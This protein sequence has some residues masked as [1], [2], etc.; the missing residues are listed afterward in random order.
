MRERLPDEDPAAQD[1]AALAR[2]RVR[3]AAV[4]GGVSL[5]PQILGILRDAPA[6]LSTVCRLWRALPRPDGTIARP[7]PHPAARRRLDARPRHAG[8]GGPQLPQPLGRAAPRGQGSM[9][10]ARDQILGSIRR[11]LKRGPPDAAQAAPLE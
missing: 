1:D 6:A 7:L 8:A 2:A 9:S 10:D 4:A 11:S 5:R 3:E